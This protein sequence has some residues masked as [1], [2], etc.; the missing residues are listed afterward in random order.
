MKFLCL[1]MCPKE[2]ADIVLN[3]FFCKKF[4]TQYEIKFPTN[5]EQTSRLTNNSAC[6]L[7]HRHVNLDECD[8]DR[9]FD[10]LCDLHSHS[11]TNDF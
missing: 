7:G 9:Y 1:Y 4:N 10:S 2:D 3:N 11:L 5:L 8:K 6:G